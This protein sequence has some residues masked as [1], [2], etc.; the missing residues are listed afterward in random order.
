[1]HNFDVTSSLL[2][3]R[4]AS[5][6]Q[7]WPPVAASAGSALG[8]VSVSEQIISI[9]CYWISD[10]SACAGFNFNADYADDP[11]VSIPMA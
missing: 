5:E 10:H 11:Q 4:R 2:D 6:R 9:I 1:M 7:T 8:S 3:R